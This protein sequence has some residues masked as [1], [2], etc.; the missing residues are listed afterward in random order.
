MYK[1][2]NMSLLDEW[3]PRW[4]KSGDL[5]KRVEFGQGIQRMKKDNW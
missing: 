5:T 3:C 4:F 2:A 1:V